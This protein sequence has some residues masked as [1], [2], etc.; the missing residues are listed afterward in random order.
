MGYPWV[1]RG[2]PVV[3]RGLPVG[4]PVCIGRLP[5]VHREA[6]RGV[7]EATLVYMVGTLLLVY[8]SLPLLVG[9]HPAHMP[10]CVP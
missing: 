3:I 6:T 5:V 1:I 9:V 8:A 7:W 10:P 2:L 4:L